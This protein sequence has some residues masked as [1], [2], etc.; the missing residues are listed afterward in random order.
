LPC[1]VLSDEAAHTRAKARF[2]A[3]NL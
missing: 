1:V 2:Q 3:T